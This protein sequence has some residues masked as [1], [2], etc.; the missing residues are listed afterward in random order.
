MNSEQPTCEARVNNQVRQDRRCRS[1]TYSFPHSQLR[2]DLHELTLLSHAQ[3]QRRVV[4]IWLARIED[5][6]PAKSPDTFSLIL[7]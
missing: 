3:V 2:Q 1:E 4:P 5:V 6:E 7:E